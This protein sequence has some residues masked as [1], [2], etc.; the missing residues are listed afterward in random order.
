MF[1]TGNPVLK[2]KSLRE[3]SLYAARDY[4]GIQGT[5]CNVC[6]SN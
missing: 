2:M 4:L 3:F 1:L 5:Q 6:Y